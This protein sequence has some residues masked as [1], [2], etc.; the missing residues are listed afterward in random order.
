MAALLTALITFN[1]ILYLNV[2]ELQ[3]KVSTQKKTYTAAEKILNSEN[4]IRKESSVHN[5]EKS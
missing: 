4:Q 5:I 1:I 2:N 3:N